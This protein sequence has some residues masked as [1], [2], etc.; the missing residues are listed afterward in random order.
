M[1]L[2]SCITAYYANL[3]FSLT[4]KLALYHQLEAIFL[5]LLELALVSVL[6]L[7]SAH[8]Y[9]EFFLGN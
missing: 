8:H 9:T 2:I 1:L 4:L 7:A 6:P 5:W 3:R